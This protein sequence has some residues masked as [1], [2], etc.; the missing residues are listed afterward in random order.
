MHPGTFFFPFKIIRPSLLTVAMICVL[1]MVCLRC[2]KKQEMHTGIFLLN[3]FWICLSHLLK[4][5]TEEKSLS[6]RQMAVE[7]F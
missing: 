7:A 3:N 5:V 4:L 1:C 6:V 2:H